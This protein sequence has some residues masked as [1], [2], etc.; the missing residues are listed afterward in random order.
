MRLVAQ[1]NRCVAEATLPPSPTRGADNRTKHALL[2]FLIENSVFGWN[3]ETVQFGAEGSVARRV[4]YRDLRGQVSPTL[5]HMARDRL[6]PPWQQKLGFS[7]PRGSAR[8]EN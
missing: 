7:H 6:I 8:G 3:E 2:G 5:E 4:N 1:N